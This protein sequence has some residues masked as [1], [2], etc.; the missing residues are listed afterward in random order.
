[1]TGKAMFLIRVKPG[2]EA[3][4]EERWKKQADTLKN[5]KGF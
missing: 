1:M 2:M 3:E 5:R 4:F